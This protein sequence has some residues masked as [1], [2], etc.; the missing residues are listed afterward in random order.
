MKAG[1][2]KH[3]LLLSLLALALVLAIALSVYINAANRRI[4]DIGSSSL[5]ELYSNMNESFISHTEKQWSMLETLRPLLETGDGQ[6]TPEYLAGLRGTWGFTEFF[7][8]EESGDYISAGGETGYFSYGKT[9]HQL[10]EHSRN[11]VVNATDSVRG[12]L[13]LFAVPAAGEWQGRTFTAIAVGYDREQV[14]QLISARAYEGST[15][16]FIIHGSG[17]VLL[18]DSDKAD[19][20][21]YAAV[22]GEGS[23]LNTRELTGLRLGLESG[24]EDV[25]QFSLDGER[26]YLIYFPVGIDDLMMVGLVP[27]RIFNA[28]AKNLQLLTVAAAALMML[29]LMGSAWA[30]ITLSRKEKQRSLAAVVAAEAESQAKSAFLA[31]MSHDIRTPINAIVG[32]STL[33]EK[34]A[35]DEAKVR[36]HTRKIQS[37]SRHL[38]E[39]INNVLDMSKIESGKL[40]INSADF[41]LLD[42]AEDMDILIRPQAE[43][44]N[45]TFTVDTAGLRAPRVT[46]DRVH[47]NQVLLNLLS[48]A[49]K[50]TPEG[51]DV[52]FTLAGEAAGDGTGSYTFTVKDNGMGMSP[53]YLRQIFEPFTREQ[54]TLTNHVQGTGLGMSITKKI[55]DALGGTISIASAKGAGSTF[56]VRLGFPLAEAP[57]ST[58]APTEAPREEAGNVFAG[59]HFLVAEDN[60]L[61]QEIIRDLLEMM[62]ATCDIAEN[63]REAV[64]KFAA[65]A[66]G[67]Y[68]A[69]FM[70]V[71]MPVMNGYE[72]T[73]ALRQLPHPEAA[74]IPVIAMTANAFDEDVQN[75]LNAGMDAHVAKPVDMKLLARVLADLDREK[76][77]EQ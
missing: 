67:T 47:L 6:V 28:T 29:I 76:A 51:G 70:D 20:S 37:S 68:H 71:Q 18:S 52:R 77:K 21:I 38:L 54:S 34:D 39:L 30:G 11:I 16:S 64:D 66:P 75:A 17:S 8:I 74:A 62:D 5:K 15:E 55:V 36:L 53:D 44:K 43:A 45:Q 12:V 57:A 27:V 59:R 48:N 72:A 2:K 4:F 25:M 14:G 63:G 31:N 7:F 19:F 61:N 73:G 1:L 42:V 60:E 56:T 22:S 9:Y 50:Y 49:V 65:S 41:S 13:T 10:F 32:L 40:V 69:V 58:P 3:A 35:G 46:G 33:L 24:G 26:Y 23:S